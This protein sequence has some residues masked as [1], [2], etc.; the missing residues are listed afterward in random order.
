MATPYKYSKS[1]VDTNLR[2]NLIVVT[3]GLSFLI[4]IGV[5]GYVL[6]EGWSILDAFYMTFISF[7]T[8]GFQEVAKLG[9]AGRLFTVFIILFG[10]VM[11]SMLSGS[12]TSIFV[13]NELLASRKIKKMKKHISSLKNFTI[14]CG[15][16][17]TG[18]NVIKEFRNAG[19]ELVVIEERPEVIEQLAET[20]PDLPVISGDATKDEALIEANIQN[21]S[22]LIATLSVD[23]DNFFVVVSA[24]ALNPKLNIISRSVDP[25]TENKLYKAGAN[26]VISPNLIGGIRMA[27]AMLRPSV[28]SFLDVMM[29]G[30]DVALRLEEV[31]VPTGA[32]MHGKTMK[33]AQI[34][35][36]T[37]LIVI[38]IKNAADGKMTFNP[39][40]STV[41]YENDIL[42]V[43][44]DPDKCDRLSKLLQDGHIAEN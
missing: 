35:Q 23:A 28:L 40:S 37:G 36:K 39:S 3:L 42:I 17:D 2:H 10:V 44:G 21:A 24:R 7:T 31:V 30:S 8:V 32:A 12:V 25:H 26:H 15:A 13:K 1:V 18:M 43:L 11:I 33:D 38:A 6:I 14:L 16:G 9:Q 20:Y 29:R 34:P 41:F 27:A 5:T 22:G 19:K 4:S